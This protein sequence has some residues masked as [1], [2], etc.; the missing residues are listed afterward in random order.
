MYSNQE[1][2][3]TIGKRT[4][5]VVFNIDPRH[6]QTFVR[7]G[8]SILNH[9]NRPSPSSQEE[10]ESHFDTAWERFNKYSI[11]TSFQRKGLNVWSWENGVI[12]RAQ[13]ENTILSE[14]FQN[15]LVDLFC[16][17]GVRMRGNI[18][19]GPTSLRE[20]ELKSKISGLVKNLNRA[21]NKKEQ[22]IS[23][24]SRHWTAIIRACAQRRDYLTS[25]T[26]EDRDQLDEMP[27]NE[28][29]ILADGR[30]FHVAYVR[31][32]DGKMRYGAAV[33]KANSSEE[34][35][36][37]NEDDHFDTAWQRLCRFGVEV[38]VPS[39]MRYATRSSVQTGAINDHD[40][41]AWGM[42]RKSIGKFG[43]RTRTRFGNDTLGVTSKSIRT[44]Q[45]NN[46]Y[47]QEKKT[48]NKKLNVLNKEWGRWNKVRTL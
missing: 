36:Y 44:H 11:L 25:W 30:I 23:A 16:Q 2:S 41:K 5:F 24:K 27:I 20:K 48:L 14:E 18:L 42:L 1:L 34:W 28:G 45:I 38:E 7:Y 15:R 22:A 19:D 29:I 46:A 10:V 12:T 43:V 26:D 37:Y 39:N 32:P 35:D 6:G 40:I 13:L 8:A 33:F 31:L 4:Y 21:K 47:F 3:F 17:Y 9:P